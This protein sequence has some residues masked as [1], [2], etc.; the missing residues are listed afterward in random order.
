MPIHLQRASKFLGYNKGSFLETEKQ[1]KRIKDTVGS[2][3]H[4]FNVGYG[5]LPDTSIQNVHEFIRIIRS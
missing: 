5:L 3:Q 2:R 4:I 1:A